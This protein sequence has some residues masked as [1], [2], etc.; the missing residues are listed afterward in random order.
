[1]D[2][3]LSTEGKT[4]EE[5]K[6]VRGA[7]LRELAR[8]YEANDPDVRWQSTVDMD[9]TPCDACLIQ[10]LSFVALSLCAVTSLHAI[11]LML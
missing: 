5:A 2:D 10:T 3:S 9:P 7:A 4:P 1:M 11:A 6:S 8:F